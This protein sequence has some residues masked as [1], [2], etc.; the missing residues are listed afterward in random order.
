MGKMQIPSKPPTTQ[1]GFRTEDPTSE[2]RIQNEKKDP[3]KNQVVKGRSEIT[4]HLKLND[5]AILAFEATYNRNL[6]GGCRLTK[7]G[8]G[9]GER[10]RMRVRVG[11]RVRVRVRFR[12]RV[13]GLGFRVRV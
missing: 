6:S 10:A 2:K 11:L 7:M 4:D 3:Y 5:L 1:S 13:L 12:V 9:E 8:K